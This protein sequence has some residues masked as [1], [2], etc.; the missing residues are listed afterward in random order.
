MTF[1]SMNA[2]DIREEGSNPGV[3]L[4]RKRIEYSATGLLRPNV[5]GREPDSN[6]ELHVME[7]LRSIGCEVAPQVGVEGYLS[8]SA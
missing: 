6:F 7:Q 1:C 4:F 2:D 8:T 3:S 5:D